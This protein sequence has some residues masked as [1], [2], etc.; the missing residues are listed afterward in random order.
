[1][2]RVDRF[3]KWRTRSISPTS[4]RGGGALARAAAGSS[5][6]T[7]PMGTSQAG[8]RCVRRPGWLSSNRSSVDWVL[9]ILRARILFLGEN[10]ADVS[11]SVQDTDDFD[12]PSLDHSGPNDPWGH[13]VFRVLGLLRRC[14]YSV[15]SRFQ[16]RAVISLASPRSR[17][18]TPTRSFASMLR[19]PPAAT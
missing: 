11:G 18:S 5:D 10:A 13:R 2:F 6:E 9:S 15:R 7:S 14:R 3:V 8:S 12:P 4:G 17:A 19:Y 16:S 1:M